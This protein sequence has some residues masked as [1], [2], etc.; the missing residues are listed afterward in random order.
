MAERGES[1]LDNLLLDDEDELEEVLDAEESTRGK[2]VLADLDLENDD[3]DEDEGFAQFQTLPK[4]TLEQQAIPKRQVEPQPL[5]AP[6]VVEPKSVVKPQSQLVVQPKPKPQPIVQPQPQPK[7][8]PMVQHQPEPQ[9]QAIEIPEEDEDIEE[10]VK[11]VEDKKEKRKHKRKKEPAQPTGK[12]AQY[13]FKQLDKEDLSKMSTGDLR[14]MYPNLPKDIHTGK[15]HRR[16]QRYIMILLVLLIGGGCAGG[17]FY[18]ANQKSVEEQIHNLEEAKKNIETQ[19]KELENSED[20][21]KRELENYMKGKDYNRA[22]QT[23]NIILKKYPKSETAKYAE[24]ETKKAKKALEKL[25]IKEATSDEMVE[26]N[27]EDYLQVSYVDL[28]TSKDYVGKKVKSYGKIL[29]KA[30]GK[31][32]DITVLRI[33]I[34]G[35][36]TQ[37]IICQFDRKK[38]SNLSEGDYVNFGGI[39]VPDITFKTYVGKA[40]LPAMALVYV[41][42]IV[43]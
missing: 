40:T 23:A 35:D 13:D 3:D 11:P 37:Q 38:C 17:Y 12:I 27:Y 7:P 32:N 18:Y 2:S 43:F 26:V 31:D 42:K 16:M 22:I 6:K 34:D 36:D 29:Q 25:G 19:Y 30:N 20:F 4:P 28:A 1:V 8:Q 9:R 21:L 14:Q 10:E 15:S 41:D 5:P 39:A 24:Q 33:A